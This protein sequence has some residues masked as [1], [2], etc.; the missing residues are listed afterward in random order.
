ELLLRGNDPLAIFSSLA[1]LGPL[2]ATVNMDVL[3]RLRDMDAERCY[4]S[5]TLRL[6]SD[7]S[8]EQ[9]DTAFDWAAGD[10]EV[11]IQRRELEGPQGREASPAMTSGSA[12]GSAAGT[13]TV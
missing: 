13:G 3:P 9:I 6:T 10:C 7:C 1:E 2:Q 4:L 12:A 8:R 11:T 5:W